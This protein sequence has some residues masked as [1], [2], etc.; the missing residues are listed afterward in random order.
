MAVLSFPTAPDAHVHLDV[1]LAKE[2]RRR[3]FSVSI[4]PAAG[5]YPKTYRGVIFFDG[6]THRALSTTALFDIVQFRV[7]C[8]EEIRELEK[9]GWTRVPSPTRRAARNRTRR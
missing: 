3:W 7:Q 8:E 1:A 5:L 6:R 9:D 2:D 4:R